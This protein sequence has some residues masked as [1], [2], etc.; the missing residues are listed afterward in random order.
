MEKAVN[1]M[2]THAGAGRLLDAL[3]VSLSV[4]PM[5]INAVINPMLMHDHQL[6]LAEKLERRG[7]IRVTRDFTADW[8]AKDGSTWFFEALGTFVPVPFVSGATSVDGRSVS[9]F[10]TIVNR[11]MGF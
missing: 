4:T 9:T 6:E 2:L 8:T 10:Q 1:V 11:V 7:A 3:P 5:V